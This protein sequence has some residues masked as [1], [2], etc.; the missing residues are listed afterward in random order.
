[1]TPALCSRGGM[2]QQTWSLP[3]PHLGLLGEA[4]GG[5]TGCECLETAGTSRQQPAATAD[6]Y[7]RTPYVHVSLHLVANHKLSR[8]SES[9]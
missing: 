1:M 4:A 6:I 7:G 5:L 9:G 3:R 8:H 2:D